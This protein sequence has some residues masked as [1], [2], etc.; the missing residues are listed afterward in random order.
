MAAVGEPGAEGR[1]AASRRLRIALLAAALL[2]YAGTRI[3]ATFTVAAN[4]DEFA[5]LDRA[6]W[7]AEHGVLG[8]G[9]RPGLATLVLLPFAADCSDEIAALHQARL[10]WAGITLC[11]LAGLAALL[12]QVCARSGRRAGDAWLGVALLALVPA[13]LEWSIQVRSDQLALAFSIWG[14]VALLASQR[15]PPL[16][17]LAGALFGAGYLATQ[18][19][20]YVAALVGVLAVGRLWQTR[21]LRPGR[22]LLRSA[23]AALAF[24]AVV[25]AFDFATAVRLEIPPDQG[26]VASLSPAAVVR[27]LSEFDYYRSTIGFSQY[28]E[29]LPTLLPH[30]LLL[31]ALLAATALATRRRG[32]GRVEI[33]IAWCV[34][35]VG[36]GVAAFHASAFAYFWMTLGLFPAVALALAGDPIRRSLAPGR[37]RAVALATG[38]LWLLL[39]AQAVARVAELGLDTQAV[40]RESLQFVQRNFATEDQGFHPE[41]APFCRP[42]SH[43]FGVYFS[44]VLYRHYGGADRDVYTRNFLA[45]LRSRHVKYVVESFRLNQ[46]PVEIRRFL[47]ENYQPYHASVFVAGRRFEGNSGDTAGFELIVPGRYRWLP[48]G[49]PHSLRIGTTRLG[50]GETF[51]AAAGPH[52]AAFEA[53]ATVGMLVLAVDEPPSLA[54][55]AFY[56]SY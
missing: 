13:F 40:Q 6:A 46:F 26:A 39:T 53:D 45:N 12:G 42:A 11:F 55:L 31:L 34:L 25:A 15:R 1:S 28:R 29:I 54:P 32:E 7:S 36:T 27:Q 44:Q 23:G 8:G 10:L 43:P 2:L 5:L 17:L 49:A 19:A 48:F 14:G 9:G 24:G 4:W 20:A 50:P 35:A 56:K 22:E 51:Q 21:E 37:Q 30:T 3:A 52:T 38:G 18:K 47:A 33:A 16:A 41:H